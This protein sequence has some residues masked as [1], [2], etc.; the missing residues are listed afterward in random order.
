MR[1][2]TI[3][4]ANYPDY[5]PDIDTTRQRSIL[6]VSRGW[7][8]PAMAGTRQIRGMIR[9]PEPLSAEELELLEQLRPQLGAGGRQGQPQADQRDDGGEAGIRRVK[10]STMRE[11]SGGSKL[12]KPTT[13]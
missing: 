13:T 1:R 5:A 8:A 4:R 2:L 11:A 7:Y 9:A 10:Y 6:R 12:L 3:L